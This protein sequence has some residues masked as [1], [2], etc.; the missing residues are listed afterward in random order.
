MKFIITTLGYENGRDEM[1]KF[2]DFFGDKI[3]VDPKT[4]ECVIDIESIEELSTLVKVLAI[5]TGSDDGI[6][7][8]PHESNNELCVIKI[9]DDFAS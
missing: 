3:K 9:F 2:P 1:P 7:I 8:N 6:I 4:A 5:D